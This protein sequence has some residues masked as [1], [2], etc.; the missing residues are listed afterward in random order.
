MQLADIIC[1]FCNERFH[2]TTEA[3]RPDV[4]PNGSMFRLKQKFADNGWQGFPEHDYIIGENICCP[5][6]GGCYIEGGKVRVDHRQYIVELFGEHNPGVSTAI[7]AYTKHIAEKG[8]Q[9][10]ATIKEAIAGFDRLKAMS[11]EYEA[12]NPE[13]PAARVDSKKRSPGRP[14]KA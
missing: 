4:P 3:Y 7:E 5:D 13:L 12:Y 10:H 14:K 6:C 2:E 8:A 1:P 9:A 11:E